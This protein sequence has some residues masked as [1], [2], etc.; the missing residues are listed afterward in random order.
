MST[1][2]VG[3]YETVAEFIARIAAEV[4]AAVPHGPGTALVDLA[5]GTGNASLH[6]AGLGA[7]VTGVDI[8]P[9]L[10]AIAAEKPG[11][12]AVEWVASD[13]SAT[14]LPGASFDAAVSNMGIIF[15]EPASMVAEIARLL[16]P[17]G[18]LGFSAWVKAADNPFFTPVVEV[19]GQPQPGPYSPEQW[20]VPELVHERLATDFTDVDI[21]NR[22]LVWRFGSVDDAVRFVTAESPVHVTTFTYLDDDTRARLIEAFTAAFAAHESSDGTVAFDAPYAVITAHRR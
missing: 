16:K 17:G 5:C 12:D 6:A 8:T 22:T 13:A 15:V 1:W 18:A 14:G 11:G 3:R 2:S 10:L 4:V 7:Q 9:E 19:L 21:Q 20:G